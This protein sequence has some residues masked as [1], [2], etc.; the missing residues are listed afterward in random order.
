MVQGQ[1]FVLIHFLAKL[2]NFIIILFVNDSVYSFYF[3]DACT[4]DCL[5]VFQ[6]NVLHVSGVVY[7]FIFLPFF[8][9]IAQIYEMY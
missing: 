8:A 5:N 4:K 3:L 6:L 9:V 2:Q 7:L 1:S